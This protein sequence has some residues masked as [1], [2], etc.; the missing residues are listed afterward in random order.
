[1]ASR[2]LSSRERRKN[3]SP[4]LGAAWLRPERI[5]RLRGTFRQ[6]AARCAAQLT[7]LT[8]SSVQVTLARLSAGKIDEIIAE[9]GGAGAASI[10]RGDQ[11]APPVIIGMNGPG[12]DAMI[13]AAFGGD[14]AEPADGRNRPLS[15]IE[16]HL[17][18][19]VAERV[20]RALLDSYAS[21]E[22][23]RLALDRVKDLSLQP[24]LARGEDEW[25][26]ARFD[27]ETPGRTGSLFILLPPSLIQGLHESQAE[28]L[29]PAPAT[30][31]PNWRARIRRELTRTHVTLQALLDEQ[32][33]TLGDLAGLRPGQTLSLRA[34]PQSPVRL[35]CNQQ[36]LFWC[37][38]GQADGTYIL[39]VH[40]F[41]D[42]EQDL[43]DAILSQ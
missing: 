24:T 10:S 1:M 13:E 41:A 3:A 18:G 40:D 4:L 2:T 22:P 35:V 32:E 30:R 17:A 5:A 39:R 37:D 8:P 42:E 20:A 9:A 14:G 11:P 34:T 7:E 36:T 16:L 28:A 12:L 21:A 38:L 31:D 15:Q 6:L 19:A 33:L 27:I 43:I 23:S 26:I 25:L 29:P